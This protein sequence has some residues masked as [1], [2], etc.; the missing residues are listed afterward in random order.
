MNLRANYQPNVKKAED[1]KS[2]AKTRLTALHKHNKAGSKMIRKCFK[3]KTGVRGS[4]EEALA[5]YQNYN[6]VPKKTIKE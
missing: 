6:P 4:Y 5:W 1:R 3:N 2:L